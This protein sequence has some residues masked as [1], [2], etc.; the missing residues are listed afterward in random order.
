MAERREAAERERV[1]AAALAERERVAAAARAAAEAAER[2]RRRRQA[3]TAI[4][5]REPTPP[6]SAEVGAAAFARALACW[7]ASQG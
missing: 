4:L 2:E 6:Q 1:A 3:P 5:R 7:V